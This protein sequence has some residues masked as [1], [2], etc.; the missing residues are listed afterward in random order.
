VAPRYRNG[1]VGARAV[2]GFA[3]ERSVLAETEHCEHDGLAVGRPGSETAENRAER[4]PTTE[5]LAKWLIRYTE[6]LE[7]HEDNREADTHLRLAAARLKELD[8]IV[9]RLPKDRNGQ[10]I[11]PGAKLLHPDAS[12][13]IWA[14]MVVRGNAG[15]YP[16]GLDECEAAEAAR[17]KG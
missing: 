16:F 11:F 14:E 2:C 10:T 5:E 6:W 13:D 8:A 12:W 1:N 4:E 17:R 15:T 7:L 3:V 9:A